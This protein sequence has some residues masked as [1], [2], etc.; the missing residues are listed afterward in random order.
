MTSLVVTTGTPI[1]YCLALT[2][3][4]PFPLTDVAWD[5]GAVNSKGSVKLTLAPGPV[6]YSTTHVWRNWGRARPSAP[7]R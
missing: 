3:N 6:T 1:Y 4:N 7:S 5:E 2:N